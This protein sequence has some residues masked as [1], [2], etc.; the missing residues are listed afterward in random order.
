MSCRRVFS[1]LAVGFLLV[2]VPLSAQDRSW[3]ETGEPVE[4]WEYVDEDIR[5]FMEAWTVPGAA[6]AVTFEGRLLFS[7]G[8]TWDVSG[9]DPIEPTSL[10]R[11]ASMSKPITSVAIHQLIER[12]LLSYDT[13]VVDILD[14][15]PPPGQVADSRLELVTVDH[16]LYHVGGWDRD[17]TFDPMFIDQQIA[18]ALGVDLPISKADIATYMTGRS[19]QFQP[20]SRY[21][22]SNYGYCLLGMIIEE[23]TG[24]DYSEWVVE[25]VFQPL[26]IGRA[27]RGHTVEADRFP[28]EVVYHGTNGEDPYHWNVEN[29]DAHGGWVLSAPDFARFMAELFDDP[30]NSPLLSRQSI[31]AMVEVS[32]TTADANYARGWFVLQDG[33]QMVYGHSGSLPGTLTNANWTSD[34]MAAVALINTRKYTADLELGNPPVIPGH[35]LFESVGI[36]DVPL[37]AAMSESWIPVVASGSG[38]GGSVWRSDVGLLNRSLLTNQVKV[39]LETQ[40][41]VVDQD[42]DLAPGQHL[43]LEDVVSQ[44]GLSGS[45]SLRLLSSE[46]LTVTS[47]SY[48]VSDEGT[49]GQSLGGVTGPGGLVTGDSAVVMHL[50]EDDVARSNIGIL[51]AGRRRAKVEVILFDG[52]GTEVAN[53]SRKVEQ[54]QTRQINRPFEGVA[55]RTDIDVGYAVVTVLEGEE[56]VVYASVVDKGTN[57]PTTIPMKT[58]A[59]AMRAFVPAAARSDGAAGS[60]WRTD[61]GLLNPGAEDTQTSVIFHASTGV[62]FILDLGLA[63]GEHQVLDDV[64]GRLG[65]DGSGFLE[66]VADSPVMVSSRTYNHGGGGTFGQYLDGVDAFGSL[67]AGRKGWLPQLQ[68]NE[69]FRTNIGILNSGEIQAKVRLHLHD[70]DG[71][72]LST[73]QRNVPSEGR[74]QFQEPFDRF[75]DRTDI[76]SGYAVI[77]C[78]VGDGV[79]GYASVVDNRTNDPMTVPMA[80]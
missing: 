33:D 46:P 69:Q 36:T 12:G 56:V 60:V 53:F 15:Q 72:L 54:G 41:V 22:Y 28:G 77:E 31:E 26:G 73:T 58:G 44:A 21:V 17:T 1:A 24:C 65:A 74:L 3:I 14:L 49:F 61:L 23:I 55:G 79:T 35:D 8:Y 57:D 32:P 20:G 42:L 50:R 71:T 45:G 34:G 75:A 5:D 7:R 16:L 13:R 64:V 11:I 29:M 48:A 39:R 9:V 25:N 80:R 47:R 18:E 30:G 38:S 78:V 63:A 10:F 70:A 51:N 67:S 62:N 19:L 52:Q 6:M 37:G 43:V 66:V 2:A 27:R 76:S 68:Q 40:D 4:G 59:G